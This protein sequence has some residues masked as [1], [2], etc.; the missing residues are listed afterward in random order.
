[1]DLN[2]RMPHPRAVPA[3]CGRD[4]G[5]CGAEEYCCTGDPALWRLWR[6]I[7]D[8]CDQLREENDQLREENA[9]LRKECAVSYAAWAQAYDA[10]GRM[11]AWM[12][13]HA[14]SWAKSLLLRHDWLPEAARTCRTALD[15]PEEPGGEH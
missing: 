2:D 8:E 15:A 11:Y 5:E 14:K 6:E 7:R 3:V 10:A 12:A 13:E 1:M 4:P 9:R